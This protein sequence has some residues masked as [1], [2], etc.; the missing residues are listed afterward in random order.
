LQNRA[1]GTCGRLALASFDSPMFSTISG[2]VSRHPETPTD[3]FSTMASF[4][5]AIIPHR[6]RSDARPLHF[7]SAVCTFFRSRR[8]ISGLSATRV[9]YGRISRGIPWRWT[10]R[11][12]RSCRTHVAIFKLTS[13]D[14][15]SLSSSV[16]YRYC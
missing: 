15:S 12:R 7:S 4:R 14:S 3:G 16:F 9:R 10:V 5:V 1:T 6:R 13:G 2:F 8:Q 11:K